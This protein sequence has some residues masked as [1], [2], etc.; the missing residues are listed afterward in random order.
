MI[1]KIEWILSMKSTYQ[2]RIEAGVILAGYLSDY[3]NRSD[4]IVLALPRGG[5]PVGFEISKQ[6]YIPLDVYI[7]RKLGVPTHPELAFG[8]VS[9]DGLSVFNEDIV[10]D[11]QISQDTIESV[12]KKEMHELKRRSEK[13]RGKKPFPVLKDRIVILVDDGIATG[14]TVRAAITGLRSMQPKKLVI[15]VPVADI[16][17]VDKLE[18]LVDQFVCPLKVDGLNA[19]GAWYEEFNQTTDEE[20][21]SLLSEATVFQSMN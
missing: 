19:V 8:A 21:T 15:A 6:L 17:V 5:V 4:A 16:A 9:M 14:A 1:S 12:I 10:N 7:V 2:D 13:Y 3:A 20:V 11:L 18:S